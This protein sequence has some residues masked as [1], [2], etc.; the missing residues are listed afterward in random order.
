[1]TKE[2]IRRRHEN[3]RLIKRM[4]NG[5]DLSRIDSTE[6]FFPPR[7]LIKKDK[8]ILKALFGDGK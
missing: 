8:K 2:E 7:A 6:T 4:N 3:D 5:E 1:M